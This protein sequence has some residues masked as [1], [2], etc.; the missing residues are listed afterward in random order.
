MCILIIQEYTDCSHY[1]TKVQKCPTFHKLQGSAGGLI[2]ALFG[3]GAPRRK[4]CGRLAHHHALS[5][6]SLCEKCVARRNESSRGGR[7]HVAADAEEDRRRHHED[8]T[9]PAND[10]SRRQQQQQ[11]R[12]RH[13]EKTRE[14]FAQTEAYKK[15]PARALQAGPSS[16]SS[17]ASGAG[18]S[19][20]AAAQQKQQ[21]KSSS[22]QK[23]RDPREGR[24]KKSDDEPPPPVPKLKKP[25]HPAQP[26][27]AYQPRG[28]FPVAAA[29]RSTATEQGAAR[30]KAPE[31]DEIARP[32]ASAPGPS[33]P[34][35]LRRKPAKTYLNVRNQ[36]LRPIPAP[37]PEYQVYLNAMPSVEEAQ[38]ARRSQ[39]S[40]KSQAT[41]ASA[42]SNGSGKT[43][44][45]TTTTTTAASNRGSAGS[46]KS[47]NSKDS[48]KDLRKRSA[49]ASIGRAVGLEPP[50]HSP[51]SDDGSDLSFVCADSRKLT[52]TGQI[53]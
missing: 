45:T 15:S 11:Q 31:A 39:D 52:E 18:R 1:S 9:R 48:G 36:P 41:A 23:H 34:Q 7:P 32:S 40:G 8:R 14:K 17:K 38:A 4:D 20:S 49:L 44:A 2:G 28:R 47:A 22:S 35:Q 10:G 19:H 50:R 30:R 16:S 5:M 13:A 12:H 43:S 24:A 51:F 37:L 46:H 53:A 25:S 26:A 27:P 3:C 42:S 29:A 6:P 33:E 21:Q